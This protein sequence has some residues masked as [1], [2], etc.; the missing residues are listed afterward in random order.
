MYITKK[1]YKT[2]LRTFDLKYDT[3]F[4]KSVIKTFFSTMFL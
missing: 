4:V 2:F 1:C 3:F